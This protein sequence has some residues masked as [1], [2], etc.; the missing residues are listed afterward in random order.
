[1]IEMSYT[2]VYDRCFIKCGDRYI[3]MALFG[4][5]NVTEFSFR[6]NREVRV[7]GWK[8]FAYSD[9]M[10]L[11]PAEKIMTIVG[12]YHPVGA[13]TGEN[14]MFHGKFLDDAAA[15]RFFENGIK[16][17]MSIEDIAW[18]TNQNT[19]VG[20]IRVYQEGF[21]YD[22]TLSS[23]QEYLHTSKEIAEWVENAKKTK[24]DILANAKA[25]SVYICLGFS[26]NEP[27]RVSVIRNRTEPYVAIYRPKRD[28][29]RTKC[30]VEEVDSSHMKYTPHIHEARVFRDIDDAYLAI[31]RWGREDLKLVPLSKEK[32]S[33][34]KPVGKYVLSAVRNGMRVYI[35]R[36]TKR[37]T[38][39]T[40]TLD[41]NNKRFR[42]EKEALRWYRDKLEGKTDFSHPE[43][44]A[45][46]SVTQG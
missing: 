19:L 29:S 26:G 30:Y 16:D 15:Y 13:N 35:Q 41:K 18:Q 23:K 28:R 24:A 32:A 5:N 4:D 6:T 27:L 11:A 14:F 42:S 31:P 10:L 1:M 40:Y 46:E 3:P 12:R 8:T 45:V 39:F 43:A 2:I 37:T 22:A 9:D 25:K 36:R 33:S 34:D 20:E 38:Y 44:F 17:A 21:N 7:R